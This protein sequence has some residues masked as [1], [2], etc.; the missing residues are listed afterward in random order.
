MSTRHLLPIAIAIV[1]APPLIALATPPAA[2]QVSTDSVAEAIRSATRLL[3]ELDT[4]EDGQRAQTLATK[5]ED[6]LDVIRTADESNP[7]LAYLYGRMLAKTG[8]QGDA[9]QQLRRFTTTREGRNEWHAYLL[10]GDLFVGEF[11]QLAKANYQKAQVLNQGESDVILGLSKCA[12]KLGHAKE[13]IAL[14]RQAVEAN[15][16]QSAKYRIQLVQALR[17]LGQWDEA[18]REAEA[19]LEESMRRVQQAPGKLTP[20]LMVDS[21]FQLLIDVFR[22]R[23]REAA[24]NRKRDL[25]F[26]VTRFASDHLRLAHYIR[27]RAVNAQ[28]M[29]VHE[30]VSTLQSGVNETAPQ[31]PIFLLESYGVILA[32]AG[33]DAVAIDV[34]ERILSTDSTNKLANDWLDRLRSPSGAGA[35]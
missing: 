7:W 21:V 26:D 1:S 14:A 32:E 31:T 2:R 16:T 13:A 30:M 28:S 9:I 3:D 22:S 18:A 34:F 29:A 12:L 10:L 19:A 33:R 27:E 24:M 6:H 20:L 35:P 5:V 25:P 17:R 8:R 4:A 15:P 11:P 23:I